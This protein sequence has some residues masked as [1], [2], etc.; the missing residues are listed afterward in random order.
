MTDAVP[1]MTPFPYRDYVAA[2]SAL[3]DALKQGPF[4]ALVTG[5]S[6]TGKTSLAR[7][8]GL[9]LDRHQNQLLYLSA[10]RVSLLSVVRYVA[11]ALRLTPKRSSLETIQ[12]IAD[13]L[14]AQP[15]QL[16][17]WIDEAVSLPADTLAELRSIAEFNC[18]APQLF[19]VILSGTPELRTLLDGPALFALKRRFT[20]RCTLEGLARDELDGLLV[21]RFGSD[22]KR[23][24]LG[25][26][27]ELFERARGT[28]ALLDGVARRA[29][30]R[31][32]KGAV[33][34]TL[35]REALDALS[36]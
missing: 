25:L 20:V 14:Q 6:G 19:T 17:V 13:L 24:P 26:R 31:A 5:A 12:V 8:T 32:G 35:M 4:Y 1:A 21:H 23:I 3:E 9:G 30:E 10:P 22:A 27:D 28:P 15:T 36:L 29:L 2:K 16:V 7:E 34:D 11:K 18:Q 33:T